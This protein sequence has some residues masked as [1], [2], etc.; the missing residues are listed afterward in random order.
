M[1]NNILMTQWTQTT[2]EACFDLCEQNNDMTIM[3]IEEGM[4][5]RNCVMKVNS[6]TPFLFKKLKDSS[7]S[8]VS[9]QL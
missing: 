6:I 3:S 1:H 2:H 7:W 8:D 9:A 4:C 5:M